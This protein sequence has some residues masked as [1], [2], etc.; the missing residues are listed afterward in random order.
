MSVTKISL[1]YW[2]CFEEQHF[3]LP[4]HS[5]L[6][7]DKNGSGKTSL[8]S[9][10]YSLLTGKPWPASKW[11]D[12]LM[13]GR[14][15]FGVSIDDNWNVTGKIAPSGRLVTSINFPDN[16][17]LPKI[18]TY[19]PADNY[20]LNLPRTQKIGVLD[21]SLTEIHGQQYSKLLE[22]LDRA[23]KGKTQLIKNFLSEGIVPDQIILDKLNQDLYEASLDIWVYRA[24]FFA[25]L[26]KHK[27]MFGN[28]I[29]SSFKNW[30]ID[31]EITNFKG[32]KLS[33]K[34]M[35]ERFN[36]EN[37]SSLNQYEKTLFLQ[38]V[39]GNTNFKSLWE[40]EL[41]AGKVLFGANRDDFNWLCNYQNATQIL[42]RGEMRL[43][44]LYWKE[45]VRRNLPENQS[46][47][48]LLDD[49]F[50]ELDST[51]EFLFFNTVKRESDFFF[52]TSTRPVNFEL[53]TYSTLQLTKAE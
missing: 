29:N 18:I 6:L 14:D 39:I 2:R 20:F 41:R 48:W 51:R 44:A 37:W 49:L 22:Q 15:Y 34:K 27:S 31:L 10:Y 46:V 1:N 9:A 35:D 38:K 32:F 45:I 24:N 43:L 16:T 40:A 23:V 42:S 21:N 13:Q 52:A 50:N 5:F 12:N 4:N 17:I 7:C 3:Y 47:I 53:A 28:W 19:L 11:K 36:W 26:F 30:Q 25:E 8:L 33:L